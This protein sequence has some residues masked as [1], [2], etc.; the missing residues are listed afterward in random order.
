MKHYKYQNEIDR[1][2]YNKNFRVETWLKILTK[3]NHLKGMSYLY[4]KVYNY[5]YKMVDLW[6][7]SDEENKIFNQFINNLRCNHAK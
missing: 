1:I 3:L 2:R 5:Y 6:L 7:N 4:D